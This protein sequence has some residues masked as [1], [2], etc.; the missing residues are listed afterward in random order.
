MVWPEEWLSLVAICSDV[1]R[2]AG[3][4]VSF[5]SFDLT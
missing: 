2:E 5:E 3:C 4:E 1:G